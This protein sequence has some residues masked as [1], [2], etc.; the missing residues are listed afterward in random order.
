MEC[1]GDDIYLF[2]GNPDDPS[3]YPTHVTA[4]DT[5]EVGEIFLRDPAAFSL[6]FYVFT[7][8][9]GQLVH[10]VYPEGQGNYCHNLED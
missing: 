1:F 3:L 9:S 10:A 2:Q 6:F 7:K 5:T 8:E 4:V